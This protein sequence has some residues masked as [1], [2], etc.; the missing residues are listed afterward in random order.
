M[1]CL[2]EVVGISKLIQN[3]TPIIFVTKY[4]RWYKKIEKKWVLKERNYYEE[5]N[6]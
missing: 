5:N 4:L 1:E 6:I 3:T 2:E